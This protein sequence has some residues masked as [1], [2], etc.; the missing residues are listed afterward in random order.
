MKKEDYKKIRVGDLVELGGIWKEQSPAFIRATDSEWW[1]IK[2][3]FDADN[4][5]VHV[6]DIVR[7]IS[8]C[9]LSKSGPLARWFK[10]FCKR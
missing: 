7:V 6:R 4:C 10:K 3:H 8:P 9:P 5:I 1:V 2:N